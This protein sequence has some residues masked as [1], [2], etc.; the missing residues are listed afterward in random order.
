V[1]RSNQ[2]HPTSPITP[3]DLPAQ[4]R[5]RA[6]DL[7]RWAAAEGAAVALER[8]ADELEAS[9][10]SASDETL[11]LAEAARESGYSADH[12]GREVA[13]G[14][15]PNAGRRH[16]PRVRR[17]DLPRKPGAL[18]TQASKPHIGR[19]DIARA[20]INRHEGGA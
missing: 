9:L 12:I 7:R 2:Q 13:R 17:A 11:T 18:L 15:I 8:A 4:W 14:H 16:A 10:R 19:E 5:G 6:A 3:S 1:S 20:V